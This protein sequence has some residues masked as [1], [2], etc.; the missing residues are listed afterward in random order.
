MQQM[1]LGIAVDQLRS[2]WITSVKNIKYA[3]TRS[4]SPESFIASVQGLTS[5]PVGPRPFGGV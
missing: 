4:E 1:G 2:P 5:T 3:R